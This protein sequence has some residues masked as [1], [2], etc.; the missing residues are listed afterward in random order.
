MNTD[1]SNALNYISPRGL[2]KLIEH[3]A[4]DS[5][6]HFSRELSSLSFDSNSQKWTALCQ[7]NISDEYDGVVLTIPAPN[8]LQLQGNF[9]S[10]V[11]ASFIQQLHR[12]QYSSRYGDSII[13]NFL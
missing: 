10:L 2:D 1:R 9:T 8:I 3:Y 6:L 11:P 5:F 13:Y 4:G 7:N 12:T